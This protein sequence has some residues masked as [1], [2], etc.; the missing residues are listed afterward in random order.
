M[1]TQPMT[2]FEFQ[3]EYPEECSHMPTFNHILRAVEQD[4]I[5]GRDISLR[6][7][8]DNPE[9]YVGTQDLVRDIA[10]DLREHIKYIILCREDLTAFEDSCMEN[11]EYEE[12]DLVISSNYRDYL[13]DSTVV[14]EFTLTCRFTPGM[15]SS[16][17]EEEEEEVELRPAY[18][19]DCYGYNWRLDPTDSTT[20][21]L[22][23]NERCKCLRDSL[24]EK[25]EELIIL[26]NQQERQLIW[27][28]ENATRC[29]RNT[30]GYIIELE[31][32]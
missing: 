28:E 26:R 19:T 13:S 3:E 20:R 15:S 24:R 29:R 30:E 6:V 14:Y 25:E 31:Q 8:F 1:A 7:I 11:G 32:D 21:E 4:V 16:E 9:T 12:E 17:E 23:R 5:N 2:S 22:I 27:A 18:N 10:R